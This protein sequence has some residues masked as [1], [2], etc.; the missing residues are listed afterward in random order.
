MR[1]NNKC[2][3]VTSI[4]AFFLLILN[5]YG[6]EPK[7]E[8]EQPQKKV[9]FISEYSSE[10]IF[11][12]EQNNFEKLIA[13]APQLASLI[14]TESSSDSVTHILPV[15]S[16]GL[17]FLCYFL[18]K[19]TSIKIFATSVSDEE[20]DRLREDAQYLMNEH[21]FDDV[22]VVTPVVPV[23][24]VV[25]TPA[26]PAVVEPPAAPPKPVGVT[27]VETLAT[28]ALN[29]IIAVGN[30]RIA[31]NR[32]ML[33]DA[34]SNRK[35]LVN[36]K[37]RKIA[38][39]DSLFTQAM[40]AAPLAD[41]VN[42]NIKL[43]TEMIRYARAALFDN[44]AKQPLKIDQFRETLRQEMEVRDYLAT[45]RGAKIC[46][47]AALTTM[48][49]SLA[50][51]ISPSQIY[52]EKRTTVALKG[53]NVW[54]SLNSDSL[55]IDYLVEQFNT[56]R[57]KLGQ[58]NKLTESFNAEMKKHKQL[59]AK[60]FPPKNRDD[61]VVLPKNKNISL[62]KRA[63]QQ[64]VHDCLDSILFMYF[65][66]EQMEQQVADLG[67]HVDEHEIAADQP[68][69]MREGKAK[70]RP[71][72]Q[73]ETQA[74]PD[75]DEEDEPE[76]E[77]PESS[78]YD[79]SDE[80][81]HDDDD[82]APVPARYVS[83]WQQRR[84]DT[85]SRL[86]NLKLKRDRIMPNATAVSAA[87]IS[88]EFK[89]LIATK[90]NIDRELIV[91]AVKRLIEKAKNL[92]TKEL[93]G[94]LNYWSRRLK[95]E[96]AA[97]ESDDFSGDVVKASH[98]ITDLRFNVDLA[99]FAKLFRVGDRRHYPE[100][101]DILSKKSFTVVPNPYGYHPE[102][103]LAN[104]LYEHRKLRNKPA[105]IG[106]HLLNC[107][108]CHFLIHGFHDK[109]APFSIVGFGEKMAPIYTRGHFGWSYFGY[110]VPQPSLTLNSM[111]IHDM[112][113][114]LREI[115]APP[116]ALNVFPKEDFLKRQARVSDSED[117]R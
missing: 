12:V 47:K 19:G 40:S 107:Q 110:N 86:L 77:E 100:L 75:A 99:K 113:L 103:T 14:S 36:S 50:S 44:E 51:L 69:L 5:A 56:F 114:Q 15:S 96:I 63:E 21:L 61:F 48:F 64:W 104:Y 3:F 57:E 115:T 13:L 7:Q 60:L 102:M 55:A 97:L 28:I 117:E 90:N 53:G 4:S 34:T 66:L 83:T 94:Y 31:A 42:G 74:Q 80:T 112:R 89:L 1:T 16:K 108:C 93:D 9:I 17:F 23:T 38:N 71:S 46:E 43:H 84:L 18:L 91:A 6:M 22:L 111:A 49:N 116:K 82:D 59:I 58:E 65:L 78:E 72:P 29:K 62:Y 35:K 106:S 92:N 81:F 70:R 87:T 2:F 45:R 88:G 32:K 41:L 33:T 85:I 109:R 68:K 76:T 101:A 26:P 67:E 27:R 11:T 10:N 54:L 105:Y 52:F 73:F 98:N 79:P 8:P 24:P 95:A 37:G 39:A 30:E 25:L 20:K